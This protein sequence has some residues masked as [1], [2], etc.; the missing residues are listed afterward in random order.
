[1]D[2]R[3]HT[4]P[5]LARG[6]LGTIQGIGG[7]TGLGVAGFIVAAFGSLGLIINARLRIPLW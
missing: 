5:S 3:W 1:V 7:S 4:R 2:L 6:V